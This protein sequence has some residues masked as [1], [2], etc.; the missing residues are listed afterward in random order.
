MARLHAAEREM[1]M[2]RKLPL[3]VV[4]LLA[5]LMLHTAVLAADA[6]EYEAALAKAQETLRDAQSKVQL[7]TTSDAL[8]EDAAK[9]AASGDFDL[10]VTLANE[11]A[12]H[13][14]LAVATAE[15]EK[16]VWQNN[17]PK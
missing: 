1:Q 16:T 17:V 8:L 13:A 15:R 14:E 3:L 6:A 4:A 2:K 9:A 11:A 12:L 7:W 5:G 10:A